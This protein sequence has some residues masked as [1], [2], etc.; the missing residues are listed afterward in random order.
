VLR[1]LDELL[2]GSFARSSALIPIYLG[3]AK[4]EIKDADQTDELLNKCTIT[5]DIGFLRRYGDKILELK[6]VGGRASRYIE[7][8]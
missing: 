7:R 8:L 6:E 4:D 5:T 2:Q 1:E 3:S